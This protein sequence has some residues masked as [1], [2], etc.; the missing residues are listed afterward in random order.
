MQK[1][2]QWVSFLWTTWKHPGFIF[3]LWHF[4]YVML[5][6]S[7]LSYLCVL[8]T[9]Q[10]LF[11]SFIFLF[12][13]FILQRTSAHTHDIR[14]SQNVPLLKSHKH[15]YIWDWLWWKASNNNK[16]RRLRVYSHASSY[17][18]TAKL[19]IHANAKS[20]NA[21]TKY[22]IILILFIV[23]HVHCYFSVI[24]CWFLLVSTKH[25]FAM[26]PACLTVT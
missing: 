7:N 5:F 3:S 23:F 26:L 1:L 25:N 17:R 22:Y 9:M 13:Y 2:F 10:K 21:D 4:M 12:F 16:K 24:A 14:T 15:G 19:K 20:L 6:S 18:G 8:S 11:C